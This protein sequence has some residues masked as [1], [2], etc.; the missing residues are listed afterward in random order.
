ME[1]WRQWP[2]EELV[3]SS[4][5]EDDPSNPFIK[6]REDLEC[7]R[8]VSDARDYLKQ[9]PPPKNPADT[10]TFDVRKFLESRG[11]GEKGKKLQEKK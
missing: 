6:S 5:S 7:E 10:S 3:Q 9:H 1:C 2:P 4:T 8:E 11:S